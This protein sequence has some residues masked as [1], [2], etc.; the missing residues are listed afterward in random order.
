LAGR[1]PLHNSQSA[2]GHLAPAYGVSC[3]PLLPQQLLPY[4]RQLIQELGCTEQEYLEFKQRIDWLSRERPAEY[5][6]IPD[7][8]NDALTVAI[9]SLVLGV[10]SQGLSL[11][12]A[13][14]PP[15]A[16]KGIENR[17]LDS[18]VGRDRFAPTYGFQASQELSRYGETIPIVFARQKY[19]Q[20]P[21]SRSDFSYVG[22]IMVA[23]KLVW[24]RMYSHGSYQSVDL[25]FLLGQSPVSRGPYDTEAARNE[26]RAG[27]YI[28]QAPLDA[29]QESDFRWYY[30]SGGEPVP[31][32]SDYRPATFEGNKNTTGQ[33]RLLG[34][35]RRY[36][37]FWIGEGE[38]DNA[39]RN[40]TFSGLES[41]GFSHAYSLTNRAVFG[42]YNG[43]PNGTPYRLN[44]E[45]VPYPGASS[46]QAGQTPVAKRFQIAGN[47]KMAGVGRN[48]ARQFGIVEHIRNGQVTTAPGDR[49]Q[50]LKVDT[51]VGDQITI[52]YNEGRVRDELYYD[53]N[54]PNIVANKNR[55][56]GDGFLYANPD[57]NAVDNRQ[58]RDAIQAEHEQQDDL[59]KIG[60]KWMIGNCI[61]QVTARNPANTIYDRSDLQPRTVTLV[62]K[63]VF[64]GTVGKVGVCHRG[65]VNTETNLPEG[66]DGAIYDIGQAWFPICKADIASFQNSRSCNVTEIGI[67]SNVWNKLNGICNFKSVPNVTKLRDYDVQNIALTAGTNQSYIQRASFFDVYVRPANQ[68]YAFNQGWEK[69]NDHP[70][71]VVGSAPQD[72]FNF[73]RIAH[74]FGQYEFRL[75]PVTSGEIN[76]IRNAD[77]SYTKATI[78][79]ITVEGPC[80]RLY[81]EGAVPYA[82]GQYISQTKTTNYGLF[83]LYMMA[84]PASVKELALA[85]EMISN[86]VYQG[87][88]S[89]YTPPPSRVRFLKAVASDALDINANGFR[90][91]N[92][93]A[94]AIDKDPDPRG[95]EHNTF[96][97]TPVITYFPFNVGGIYT[98]S[99]S[100][101]TAFRYDQG[102][103][104]VRLKMKLRLYTTPE[105]ITATN[106]LSHWW[107]IVEPDNIEILQ[108]TGSW[109][110]N[111]VFV[112]RSLLRNPAITID[113]YFQIVAPVPISSPPTLGGE[114]TFEGNVGIA[115]VSH[116]ANLISRSC[117]NGPEHEIVYI[118]ETVAVRNNSPATYTGC[119]MAGL[120]LRSTAELNQLEQLHIY[121]KNGISVTNLRLTSNG[122][123]VETTSSSNIFTD[124]AYYLLTN[125]QTGAGELIS[126]DLIDKAQFARTA[127]FLEANYLYYDDVIVEPQ[128]LREFLARISTSLLCN[129]VMR[130]GKF[131]I[132]P[133]LPIDTT[134]NYTM[135]DV[136]VPI[137]GIFTEGNIIEDSFQL[138]YIQAQ[139]RL[140]IRAMVRY[141]TELPNRFPQ[142]QTAVVYY[143]DQPNG[144]LE[145]FNFTHITSRYHAELFAKYAL[146]ARRH[147]THVVSF[148]TL[149]YGL[150]LAPGD[151]IRVVTQASYVQ[152]GASGIIKD[153]GAIITPAQLTNGQSVQVYYWDRND[154]EVNEDTLTIS[155][156]DGQ[157]KANKLFGSIFAI[158][159]TTTRSLVYMVD[160][161]DLDEE[162]LARISASYFPIDENGYSVVANE[163]KPS[164]NGFTVVSDLAPD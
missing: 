36:G 76:Q 134:R 83:T 159:D 129:L 10:V 141:R 48:Y 114:R 120:K 75:R 99:E 56:T 124:L 90:I 79:G 138:E 24:S 61:F 106:F 46:E 119:A 153:N 60:T 72:Q 3:T 39:F 26:D 93:I 163:L 64:D 88:A 80:Y 121:A 18:I 5:A 77:G 21:P 122:N 110:G 126:S 15:S 117:D 57:V 160:S 47:P 147:R 133:A 25:V 54:N 157:P 127:M 62:C 92:G 6:H 105:N 8:Q 17:Q 28:G 94:K 42:V 103:R 68:S 130:G 13:P 144:P 41:T 58:V 89:T 113:Y 12:L 87:G 123:I 65:F 95:A 33:S 102:G 52:I 29:L 59:L 69:L 81:V 50:G 136:K 112:I 4:E 35:H 125:I 161:I 151:F 128:N 40:H 164:Y 104:V 74:G 82:E 38:R 118:N 20:L 150:G 73:I 16:P 162:G 43:L 101:S 146:S 116:Y 155:I 158:K 154:N 115:E 100:D 109:T 71:A 31:N 22:G 135:F 132:E 27:I 45:I 63:E 152:P 131:S 11:L 7:V 53:N 140:P 34:L 32:S 14:R 30:Y 148:Q 19:V 107:E 108:L 37:D 143:T 1:H 149:P 156:V 23:P 44:W 84:K 9:I 142:E 66:P 86:P 67:K 49:S 55:N 96:H 70:F 137:S 139:E 111:E 98:F 97:G 85:P 2:S 91:S 78:N 51:Q 145:E